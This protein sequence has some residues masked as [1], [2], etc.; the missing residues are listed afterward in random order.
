MESFIISCKPWQNKTGV[1]SD[2]EHRSSVS[3]TVNKIISI[4][5]LR[6][7]T[8]PNSARATRGR[9]LG[10]D[11]FIPP[12]QIST[13]PFLRFPSFTRLCCNP[14]IY[15]INPIPLWYY[16]AKIQHLS[17]NDCTKHIDHGCCAYHNAAFICLQC[18]KYTHSHKIHFIE[19]I[20][21][22]ELFMKTIR[23]QARAPEHY[24]IWT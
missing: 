24:G 6:R 23:K 18:S 4:V 16:L 14:N 12:L 9:R 5:V 10:A 7:I 19:L 11:G 20:E 21:T 3:D 22:V 2:D 15:L 8:I 13:S 1:W 17:E